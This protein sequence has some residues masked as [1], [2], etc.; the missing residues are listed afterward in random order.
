MKMRMDEQGTFVFDVEF[1]KHYS[2]FWSWRKRLARGHAGE[3]Q[4]VA[5][6]SRTQDDRG[7]RYQ[8]RDPG[9]EGDQVQGRCVGF[10]EAGVSA[11]SICEDPMAV[12][13]MEYMHGEPWKLQTHTF[14]ASGLVPESFA[15]EEDET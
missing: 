11:V 1:E 10:Y 15:G 9:S 7:E 14:S 3:R 13:P 12:S 2:G 4:A 5:E 6:E 8:Y